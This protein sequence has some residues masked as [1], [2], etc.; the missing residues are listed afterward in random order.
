PLPLPRV[1]G[2]RFAFAAGVGLD[3]ELVRRV[4][5]LG[6]REDGRRPGDLAYLAVATKLVAGRRAR[7]EPVLE[8]RGRGRP[9]FAP[10]AN[11]D[12]YTYAGRVALHV[13]PEARFE[14]GL[15]LVAPQRVGPA[16]L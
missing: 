1:N 6:R 13:A 7:F 2:R 11:P 15:A 4:D 14:L 8:V 5:A 16:T 12:P 10:A 3:A 9:A